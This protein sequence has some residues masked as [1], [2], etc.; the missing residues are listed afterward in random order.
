MHSPTL[1]QNEWASLITGITSARLR[2]VNAKFPTSILSVLNDR[3][4]VASLERFPD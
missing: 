1:C 3:V 4:C 2:F